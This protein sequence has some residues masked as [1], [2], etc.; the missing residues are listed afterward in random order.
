MKKFLI[1]W[2]SLTTLLSFG[3]RYQTIQQSATG[4]KQVVFRDTI[5]YPFT[6]SG[7]NSFK[8]A[9]KSGTIPILAY[10]SEGGIVGKYSYTFSD[11]RKDYLN[12][13]LVTS[14][15]PVLSDGV[16][17]APRLTGNNYPFPVQTGLNAAFYKR[18]PPFSVH[19]SKVIIYPGGLYSNTDDNDFLTR[20]WT[21][22]SES[23]K[24]DIDATYPQY[25]RALE[26]ANY[27]AAYN[28]AQSLDNSDPRKQQLLDWAGPLP[29][30]EG[31]HILLSNQDAAK[32][33]AQFWYNTF[34]QNDWKGAGVDYFSVNH[35]VFTPRSGTGLEPYQQWYRQ[36]GW[37]SAE[38]IRLAALEGKTLP[39]C[40]TD[41]G[42]LA[43]AA[44]YFFDDNNSDINMPD[45]Y[46]YTRIEE[47]FRG[48]SQSA[49]MGAP[50][51]LG[52]LVKSGKAYVGVGSYVQH[53]WDDQSLFEKWSNGSY[54]LDSLGRL[55]WRTD[56]RTTSIGGQSAV[57]YNEDAYQSQLK[58]YGI[59]ARYMA[60]Q[61]F[62]AG[63]VHLPRS[64]VRQPGFEAVKFSRQFRLDTEVQS[65]MTPADKGLTDE[66]FATLNSRPLN[67]DWTEADA[68]GAYLFSDYLRGWMETQPKSAL[69][70]NNGG[71]SRASVEM[72]TKGW[73]LAAQLNWIFDTPW[74]LVQPKHWVKEQG[75]VSPATNPDEQFYR[76]PILVG[77]LAIKDGHPTLW[78][79]GWWPCQD[80]DKYTSVIIWVDKGAGQVSPGYEIRLSGRK[81]FLDYWRLPDGFA[82][83]QPKHV[84]YQFKSLLGETITWRGDY[85]EPKI[86]IHPAPPTVLKSELQGGQVTDPGSV[87]S[88]APNWIAGLRYTYN[89]PLL[90]FEGT[91]QIGKLKFERVDN[92]PFWTTNPDNVTVNSGEFYSSGP[93]EGQSPYDKQWKLYYH[94]AYPMRVTAQV[95]GG[96]SVY[97]YTVTPSA[98]A[99]RM[100]LIGTTPV[101]PPTQDTSLAAQGL[102]PNFTAPPDQGW[103][104]VNVREKYI[105]NNTLKVGFLRGG[106]VM[107][108]AS[109][110]NGRNLINS[111]QIIWT[112]NPSDFRYNTLTDDLGRQGQ[113]HSDY[114]TPGPNDNAGQ[115]LIL[116]N[117]KKTST[118]YNG[119]VFN[120]GAN[121]VPGGS[122]DPALDLSPILSSAVY[123]HPTRGQEFYVKTRP[124]IWGLKGELGWEVAELWCWFAT[125][126]TIGWFARHHIEERDPT[127]FDEQ[128]LFYSMSQEG[129]SF[130]LVPDLTNIFIDLPG[131]SRKNIYVADGNAP[132]YLTSTCRIGAFP[133]S[134]GVGVTLYSPLQGQIGHNSDYLPGSGPTGDWN[135]YNTTY[136]QG[137]P[138]RNYDNA[139]IYEDSGFITFGT[140]A[141]ANAAIASLPP[142]DQS[143]DFDFTKQNMLWAN[144]NSRLIKE[145]AGW[146]LYLDPHVDNGVTSF[147]GKIMSPARAWKAASVSAINFEIAVTGTT[148]LKLEWQ[149]PGLTYQ[150][151]Y[152]KEFTV[153]NDG[154]FHTVSVSTSDSNF[155]GIISTMGFSAGSTTGT[156]A[157]VVIKRI[158]KN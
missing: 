85:R 69:G 80:V 86:T 4:V 25:R 100:I 32:L 66:Q 2:L 141:E 67:P 38:I 154:Q 19:P 60:N 35:E 41:Q 95:A 7:D 148:T 143:F 107:S 122:L 120:T 156:N 51:D 134:G 15:A 119:H 158:W 145:S 121:V 13:S 151:Q 104:I 102:N 103:D 9:I 135:G 24:W 118:G 157:K 115:G 108:Y 112:D 82:D 153:A 48:S 44:P 62:R 34:K 113:F 75:I 99:N 117:G 139:G 55:I 6:A 71:K 137:A 116:K 76:K 89:P 126:T 27:Q 123:T 93:L 109:R 127:R 144:G 140:E 155:N 105:Q 68:I 29:A 59:F 42:N 98:G 16:R 54:K 37:I 64:D 79:Y 50:T 52:L 142:I 136:I 14:P 57:L 45:Y 47:P 110:D 106:G 128:R 31:T 5:T 56:V 130:F 61:Y 152:S 33:Y 20:G 124:Y 1:L 28:A 72:Y 49:P 87:T 83:A 73:H 146:T 36:V 94:A 74:T 8:T 21:H 125:P 97:S 22:T 84:Y 70:S 3:Q 133:A 101:T 77:G 129:P 150:N 10:P 63:G 53:T 58:F 111:N 91:G 26:M 92:T 149:K 96:T 11:V 81:A 78:Q 23:A 88:T 46:S 40:L 65:G 43:H 114:F 147:I 12:H 30:F 17:M 131:E 18:I 132:K 90:T 138:T 39:T